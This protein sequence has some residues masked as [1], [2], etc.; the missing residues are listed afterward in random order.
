MNATLLA[1]DTAA[2]HKAA[3]FHRFEVFHSDHCACYACGSTFSPQQITAW[4]DKDMTALCPHCKMDAVIPSYNGTP[5][6][7]ETLQAVRH[8]AL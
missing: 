2:I 5:T 6:D 7:P 1:I 4:T 3:S 8:Y